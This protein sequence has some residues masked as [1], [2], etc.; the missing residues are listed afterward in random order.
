MKKLVLLSL[1]FCTYCSFGQNQSDGIVTAKKIYT[2]SN[3]KSFNSN[4]ISL[5]F[6]NI[7]PSSFSIYNNF[8]GLNDSYILSNNKL[9]YSQSNISINKA[10]KI[11]SFN[12]SGTQNI[13]FALVAGVFNLLTYKH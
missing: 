8:T 10:M 5:D 2:F 11:D 13:G 7:K 12:P 9:T 3:L 1:L 6:K 4:S